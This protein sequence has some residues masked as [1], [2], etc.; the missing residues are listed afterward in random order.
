MTQL[1]WKE[2]TLEN[3]VKQFVHY[4][5]DLEEELMMLPTDL[6][7]VHDKA[8]A[9]YVK[10]YAG[11]KEVFYRD[12]AAAFAK[13]LELGISRDEHGRITNADNVGGGYHSAPKKSGKPGKPKDAG[14]GIAEPL[15]EENSQFRSKL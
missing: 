6:A 14:D 12:F 1:E 2:K 3:G 4:D 15:K 13:L 10:K 9:P 8:F 7:L 11:D 5:E